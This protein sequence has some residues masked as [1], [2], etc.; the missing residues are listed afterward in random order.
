[1]AAWWSCIRIFHVSLPVTETQEQKRWLVIVAQDGL[2]G[3][4][5]LR[6]VQVMALSGTEIYELVC[7]GAAGGAL[8]VFTR[9]SPSEPEDESSLDTDHGRPSVLVVEDDAIPSKMMTRTL[10]KAG[11]NVLTAGNGVK[12]LDLIRYSNNVKVVLLDCQMPKLDGAATLGHIRTYFKT[13]KVIGV[14][15]LAPSSIPDSY[16]QDVD[17]LLMKP[18]KGSELVEAVSSAIGVRMSGE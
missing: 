12:G 13:V 15:S 6:K 8:V 16:R 2:A 14:T 3:I 5:L 1:M 18:V 9:R 10:E 17:L 4:M 7:L 11:F